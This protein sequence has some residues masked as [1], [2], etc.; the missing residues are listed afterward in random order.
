MS[1][2]PAITDNALSEVFCFVFFNSIHRLQGFITIFIT[3]S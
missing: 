3:L 2:L 1:L